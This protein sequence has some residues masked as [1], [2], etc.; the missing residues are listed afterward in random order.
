MD[1]GAWQCG[2]ARACRSGF[3][4]VRLISTVAHDLGLKIAAGGAL[5]GLVLIV[6]LL[7]GRDRFDQL[8][9]SDGQPPGPDVL[10]LAPVVQPVPASRQPALSHQ[11]FWSVDRSTQWLR[12]LHVIAWCATVGAVAIAAVNVPRVSGK[13]TWSASKIALK[14]MSAAVHHHGA[15]VGGISLVL[16]GVSLV[17]FLVAAILT[18]F[19]YFGRGGRGPTSM[20][21]YRWVNGVAIG[22]LAAS[23]LV[24]VADAPRHHFSHP[25]MPYIQ[26]A[27][28]RLAAVQAVLLLALAVCVGFLAR[29]ASKDSHYDEGY[30]PMLRGSLAV[31]VP[32]LGWLLA[33]ALGSGYG[34]WAAD[35]M[36]GEAG[37][38]FRPIL[39]ALDRQVD[40][41]AVAAVAVVLLWLAF[42][43]YRLKSGKADVADQIQRQQPGYPDETRRAQR[44]GQARGAARW[45]ILAESVE[46]IP[47]M[48]AAVAATGLVAA[49]IDGLAFFHPYV[50]LHPFL[51]LFIRRLPSGLAWLPS[52][53]A[54][55]TT[56]G[57]AVVLLASY[58][59]YRQPSTRRIVGILWDVTTFWPKA[60]HP[61]TPA[62]SAQ[63]AV[64]QL[65][66][67]IT[68]LTDAPG[69]TLVLSAHS[70]GSI[71]GAAALLHLNAG[72]SEQN[73]SRMALLTYGSPLRRLYARAFPA[74]FSREVLCQVS[75]RANGSW[76]NLWATT[77]PVGAWIA[78]NP[79]DT[80]SDERDLRCDDQL[81]IPDPLSLDKDPRTGS[82]LTV[83]DH[84]GYIHR[85]EYPEA[86]R[87]LRE[88]LARAAP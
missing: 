25:A 8:P 61:L 57:T 54:W 76:Q 64:P 33:L 13:A 49:A 42:L 41:W 70:Q 38:K 3:A 20:R 48:L 37:R 43:Y 39:P 27:M 22:W 59:A 47:V 65:R 16:L 6:M 18:F 71:L 45:Q 35:R 75:D 9:D 86:L 15:L 84:S 44:M 62:C 58:A 82:Y 85:P 53:G 2:S 68:T 26:G 19:P 83:C 78:R 29:Q 60:N 7:A 34:Q 5:L 17:A 87:Q 10:N 88:R 67:R 69:S 31:V 79:D 1:L 66:D 23:L 12:S 55:L 46:T 81:M 4:P 28:T 36:K 14:M 40:V 24:T 56:T 52:A 74:Y 73:L 77:D 72:Q 32:F 51:P 80:E 30:R 21:G 50:Q 11:G 63:R